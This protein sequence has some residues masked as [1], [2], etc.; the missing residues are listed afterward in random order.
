MRIL[1]IPNDNCEQYAI[2][3]ARKSPLISSFKSLCSSTT[4]CNIWRS[5]CRTYNCPSFAWTVEIQ[6]T[7]LRITLEKILMYHM[8]WKHDKSL[9]PFILDAIK[10][11]YCITYINAFKTFFFF[12]KRWCN[13]N[14]LLHH[15]FQTVLNLFKIWSSQN[16]LLHHYFQKVCKIPDIFGR[17]RNSGSILFVLQYSWHFWT[18]EEFWI[19]FICTSKFLTFLDG[20]GI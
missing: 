4:R 12:F 7:A 20:G 2:L 15:Y 19:Y 17:W 11:D 14:K 9:I 8:C 1:K 13:Q 10:T 16:K 6:R 3:Q 5:R 18:V